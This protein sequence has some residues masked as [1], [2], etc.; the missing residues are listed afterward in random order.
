[1]AVIMGKQL[2]AGPRHWFKLSLGMCNSGWIHS[3]E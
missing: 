2:T 1:M 3:V